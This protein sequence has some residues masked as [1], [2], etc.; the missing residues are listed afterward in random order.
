MIKELVLSDSFE[1][2]KGEL[3][4]SNLSK[5][6]DFFVPVVS[7]EKEIALVARS[8][9]TTGKLLLLQG[10]PGVGKST[11]IQSLKWRNHIPIN[12][13]VNID[14]S[15][16]VESKLTNLLKALNE[17]CRNMDVTPKKNG[18][19]LFVVDY[20]ES[21]T[22]ETPENKKAFFR[23]LNGL[24]RTK[25]VMI[26]WPITEQTDVE[27]MISYSS[28]VS[29]TLFYRNKEVI[30]FKGPEIENFPT[31]LKN[32]ISVL[33]TGYTYTDFQLTDADFDNILNR[34]INKSDVFTLRD[35]I[36]ELR[37]VWM[38]RTGKVNSILSS[39]PKPTE[40]WFVFGMPEAEELVTPFIRK[41]KNHDDSWDAY[42]AKLD[43]YIH[44]NQ[45]AA[46]WNP[47]RLQIAISGS[48][49]AKLFHLPTHTLVSTLA[50]YGQK[51]NL[52][53]KINWLNI[54]IDKNW[55]KTSTAK[56]FLSNPSIVRYL[57]NKPIQF[58]VT[59]SGPAKRA[60][61]KGRIAYLEIN[62]LASK[63]NPQRDGSDKPF[64]KTIS[65]ALKDIFPQY[66]ID[67]ETTHPWLPNIIPDIKLE[68]DEKIICIEFHYTKRNVPS[69]I[70]SYVLDKLD[71]YMR[72]LEGM[73]PKLLK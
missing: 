57:E 67:A 32:T 59:R 40:I 54:G 2:M 12:E 4:P 17:K 69:A 49:K 18:V 71:N 60:I 10:D 61:E 8:I 41:S 9:K 33:N 64:N 23:S 35:Y 28:A 72:Q 30:N 42:H 5:M 50:A 24:L 53:A 22:D 15:Q 46:Y 43:E 31:I 55:L 13:I 27:D 25:P 6:M 16:F 48:F 21:L 20:L 44:D 66:S 70:A 62:A 14:M 58:G 11:F 51:Y 7:A 52:D 19:L 56:S 73:Y 36:F 29:G 45:R 63:Y 26:I 3:G 39:I 47:T 37:D 34:L 65:D 1:D 68:T 38:D